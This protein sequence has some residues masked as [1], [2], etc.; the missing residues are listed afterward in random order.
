MQAILFD[1][2]GVVIDT[3]S[4]VYDFWQMIAGR[5]G[6]ELTS[7]DYDT[8]IYGCPC[9]QTLDALFPNLTP[10]ERE[11]VLAEERAYETSVTYKPMPG[12]VEL[13]AAFREM[14]V[15]TALVTS[16]EMWKVDEV[17]R[18]LAFRDLFTVLV[19]AEDIPRGKPD[20]ACYLLGAWRLHTSVDQCLVFEDS[21]SGTQAAVAAGMCCIGV[22]PAHTAPALLAEGARSVIPDFT[23]V[24]LDHGSLLIPDITLPLEDR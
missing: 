8:Y 23:A 20:P 18:Q 17:M 21:I 19:T 24:R 1:M 5:Y 3:Q 6:V 9:R 16:G 10:T 2:D 7:S 15:P 4:A 12:I 13:L 11:A 14:H 22:R